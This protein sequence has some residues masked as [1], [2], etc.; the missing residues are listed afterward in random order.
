MSVTV[1]APAAEPTHEEHLS[2]Q[3]VWFPMLLLGVVSVIAGL[4]AISFTFAATMASV[5]LLGILLLVAGV[6]EVLNGVLVRTGKSFALHLLAAALYL[7][8]GVFVL[9]DPVQ[10][11]AVLTL[12]LAAAFFV[13]G[14]LRI[15]FAVAVRFPSWGWVLLN[16]VVDLVLGMMI[17]NRWPEAS[18]WVLGLFVGIDLLF[19]GWSWI[20]LALNVRSYQ[21]APPT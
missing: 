16:G 18:L 6:T 2:L 20:I 7:I 17:F 8:V 10:A 12:L 14:L 5:L 21:A 11:A 19:H 3:R 4:F 9:E 13:G 15:V 1:Q